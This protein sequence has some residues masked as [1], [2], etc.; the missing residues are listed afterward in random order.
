MPWRQSWLLFLTPPA[1][2]PHGQA[3]CSQVLEGHSASAGTFFPTSHQGWHGL[4]LPALSQL[5]R[6]LMMPCLQYSPRKPGPILSL[7]LGGQ[8]VEVASGAP[9]GDLRHIRKFL[10]EDWDPQT[11]LRGACCKGGGLSGGWV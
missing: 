9:W 1:C 4:T 8:P 5:R 7:V 2:Q 10:A 11:G 6:V 3:F